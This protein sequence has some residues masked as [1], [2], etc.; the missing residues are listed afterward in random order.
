MGTLRKWKSQKSS[1]SPHQQLQCVLQALAWRVGP[2]SISL[3]RQASGDR[4][5]TWRQEAREAGAAW[6]RRGVA[7]G[8]WSPG[9]ADASRGP[10][11]AG[12]QE[13]GSVTAPALQ[14]W[15]CGWT[16]W[17]R[18]LSGAAVP[19]SQDSITNKI[20]QLT[21]LILCSQRPFT[22]WSL[23][24]PHSVPLWG[25]GWGPQCCCPG[26]TSPLQFPLLGQPG[27]SGSLL[28]EQLPHLSLD[29]LQQVSG[30]LLFLETQ[31]G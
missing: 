3:T 15:V 16:P 28:S 30:L 11:L 6:Q 31:T 22:S 14:A 18:Q 26:P 2:Q 19:V 8:S 5:P 25:G 23:H 4:S 12:C 24:G 29:I 10:N 9:P 1:L 21:V 20:K 7:R 27:A 17:D 13:Q